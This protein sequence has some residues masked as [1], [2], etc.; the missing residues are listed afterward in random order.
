MQVLVHSDHNING[1]EAL[2][3]HIT[4]VVDRALERNADRITRVEVHLRDENSDKKGGED[5][6]R[7]TMEARVE[8]HQSLVVTQLHPTLH[9]VVDAAADK[10]A[11]LV[12][13]TLDRL[14][15]GARQ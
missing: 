10:L 13:H 11:R 15:A 8:G 5:A 6:M 3:A 4:S 7:C 1:R 12:T 2:S 9:G 14:S